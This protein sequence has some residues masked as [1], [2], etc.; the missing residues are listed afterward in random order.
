MHSSLEKATLYIRF[1]T[2][3]VVYLARGAGIG[4]CNSLQI[5]KSQKEQR[6]QGRK[7]SLQVIGA[8]CSNFPSP[9]KT[10]ESG[11]AEGD[12]TLIHSFCLISCEWIPPK[13]IA[14]R[15]NV[16]CCR[17]QCGTRWGSSVE[18]S[19]KTLPPIV[20]SKP[21]EAQGHAHQCYYQS[22]CCLWMNLKIPNKCNCCWRQEVQ[23]AHPDCKWNTGERSRSGSG[24]RLTESLSQERRIQTVHICNNEDLRCRNTCHRNGEA[25]HDGMQW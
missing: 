23:L 4:C 1:N 7:K 11:W 10:G 9:Q 6:L 18:Y 24:F 17:P 12:P 22:L 3:W 8:C 15:A 25:G 21:P 20:Q 2:F 16:T 5:G 19:S 13:W 14:F